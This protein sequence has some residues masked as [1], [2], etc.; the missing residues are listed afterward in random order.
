V[1]TGN[2]PNT[3][4]WHT[5]QVCQHGLWTH[6]LKYGIFACQFRKK[7]RFVYY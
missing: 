4:F 2:N 5:W 1:M 6:L 7:K 3:G